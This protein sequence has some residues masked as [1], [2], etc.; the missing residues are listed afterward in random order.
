MRTDDQLRIEQRTEG[1]VIVL[2]LRGEL[3]IATA[4]RLPQALGAVARSGTLHLVVD[5]QAVTV[6]DSVGVRSLLHT[7]RW[8]F[9]RGGEARFVCD[10]GPA[11]R[12]IELMGLRDALGVSADYASAVAGFDVTP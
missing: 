12:T 9:N 1:I 3:D 2:G 5:L 11:A 7:R 8:M 10:G 4:A 6:L